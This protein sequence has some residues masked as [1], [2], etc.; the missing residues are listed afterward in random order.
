MLSCAVPMLATVTPLPQAPQTNG[1]LHAQK[2][3]EDR[4]LGNVEESTKLQC[5]SVLC[6]HTEQASEAKSQA[7][8]RINNIGEYNILIKNGSMKGKYNQSKYYF[9]KTQHLK[10]ALAIL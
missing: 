10:K 8:K 3:L 7:T 4:K 9:L 2:A 1:P 6:S 5:H